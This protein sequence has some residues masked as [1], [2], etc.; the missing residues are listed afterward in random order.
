MRNLYGGA[1]KGRSRSSA[2]AA[3]MIRPSSSSKEAICT[4]GELATFSAHRMNHSERLDEI[5]TDLQEDLEADP[6][7]RVSAAS[8]VPR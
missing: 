8:L 1:R 7:K 3:N 5:P 2:P 4:V 6:D